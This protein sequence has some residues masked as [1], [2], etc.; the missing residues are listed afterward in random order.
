MAEETK[1]Y[2]FGNEGNNTV[3]AWALLG[4][5]GFGGFG[6]NGWGG[7]IIGFILGALI[8][9]GGFFGNGWGNNG[10]GGAGLLGNQL[11]NDNNTDLIMNAINGTDADVRM[12]AT[13][14]NADV[15]EV[16]NAINTVQS[17]IQTV[18]SQV[19]MSGLQVINSIQ[20]GNASLSRQLCECCCENRLLTTE[21]GYQ[22]QLRT[23]EQTNQL[24]S[25]A[26]RNAAQIRSDIA[27]Q[28]TFINEKFCD[29]EKRELQSK[30]DSLTAN[31]TLLRTQIDNANQT[32]QIAAMI[33]P[34]Q[35]KVNEIENKQLPTV[36]VQY[37]NIQAINNT[38]YSGGFWNNGFWGNGFG[39]NIV[40]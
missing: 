30:I 18:G 6:G 32:A 35:A 24:G 34:V 15:N 8:G 7:G 29:L 22:A 36:P 31:N 21:Q 27:M 1:T 4:N 12:L 11:N 3:P 20:N 19:G 28:T 16:R 26:D 10:F 5:N 23:V 17:A 37:P 38:P 13:T 25:Q 14:I 39:G 40:F 2:V 33:A 9:N